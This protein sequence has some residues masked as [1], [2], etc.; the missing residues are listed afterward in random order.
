M[1]ILRKVS[2]S[3]MKEIRCMSVVAPFGIRT[4]ENLLGAKYEV[5]YQA[6]THEWHP[7][8]C[9]LLKNTSEN[10]QYKA[11]GAVEICESGICMS[12]YVKYRC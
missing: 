9:P 6:V 5:V 7:E 8:C 2:I 3:S 4:L 11:I 1:Y 10:I 12:Y